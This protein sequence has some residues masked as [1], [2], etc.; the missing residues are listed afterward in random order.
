M[1]EPTREQ[2]KQVNKYLAA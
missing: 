1:L 2:F